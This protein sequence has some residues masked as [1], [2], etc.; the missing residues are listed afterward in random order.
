M[1]EVSGISRRPFDA[2]KTA[3][4]C[5]EVPDDPGLGPTKRFWSSRWKPRTMSM[6]FVLMPPM[7]GRS[8]TSSRSLGNAWSISRDG[9]RRGQSRAGR[10]RRGSRKCCADDSYRLLNDE[11][12]LADRGGEIPAPLAGRLPFRDRSIAAFPALSGLGGLLER[13]DHF[14]GR[15]IVEPFSPSSDLDECSSKAD[16]WSIV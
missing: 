9:Q 14:S 4:D 13:I 15:A 1:S 5:R 10:T 11:K 3:S 6:M 7:S 8:S 12:F 2:E 16:H